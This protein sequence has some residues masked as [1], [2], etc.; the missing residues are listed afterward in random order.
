MSSP[1]YRCTKRAVARQGP[2]ATSPRTGIVK[3]GEIVEAL[4]ELDLGEQGGVRV[5]GLQGWVGK[6]A[7]DSSVVLEKLPD[8]SSSAPPIPATAVSSVGKRGAAAALRAEPAS[9]QQKWT[10]AA[11]QAVRSAH[12]VGTLRTEADIDPSMEDRGGVGSVIAGTERA[13]RVG[14]VMESIEIF[15]VFKP[16]KRRYL[17]EA[18]TILEVSPGRDI[19]LEG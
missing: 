16:A 6:L 19:I 3:V 11:R 13:E 17:A 2:G 10:T 18:M 9:A 1:R 14:A 4:E 12:V 7:E 15:R 8:E 5:R